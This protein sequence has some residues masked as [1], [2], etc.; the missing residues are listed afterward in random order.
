MGI[1]VYYRI[2]IKDFAQVAALIYRLF[3]KNAIFEWGKEQTEAMDLLK[4]ALITPPALVSLDY[5]D[6]ADNIFLH[7]T[8]A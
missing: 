7:L 4:L 8:Q 5:T 1:C 3:K 6:N 2:W